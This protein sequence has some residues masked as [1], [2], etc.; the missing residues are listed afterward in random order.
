MGIRSVAQQ[1]G[2]VAVR[3]WARRRGPGCTP[4][5][6]GPEEDIKGPCRSG[7]LCAPARYAT[8]SSSP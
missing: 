5:G 7:R 2:G 3:C 4:R 1:P 6:R 8:L